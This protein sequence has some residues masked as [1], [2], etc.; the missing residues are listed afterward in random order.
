LANAILRHAAPAATLVGGCQHWVVVSGLSFEES[1]SGMRLFSFIIDDPLRSCAACENVGGVL[2]DLPLLNTCGPGEEPPSS[3]FGSSIREWITLHWARGCG[4]VPSLGSG[5]FI[6]ITPKPE[7]EDIEVELDVE[8]S[9]VALAGMNVNERSP[10]E[11]ADEGIRFLA[12][13]KSPRF[14]RVLEGEW[15]R[16]V[17]V[18]GAETEPYYLVERRDHQG[19]KALFR[20]DARTGTLLGVR[21]FF[22]SAKQVFP[23]Y[24][25]LNDALRQKKSLMLKG[26]KLDL[27]KGL[28]TEAPLVWKASPKTPSPYQPLFRVSL[29]GQ[30]LLVNFRGRIF[31]GQE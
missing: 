10:S 28:E 25:R 16:V 22:E 19:T 7:L 23:D 15:G 18:E 17:K 20:V 1:A 31:E 14:A 2:G 5:R 8:G 9:E 13:D 6:T 3:F 27:H 26:K 30:E 12:L 4:A 29:E 21:G 24:N 11:L